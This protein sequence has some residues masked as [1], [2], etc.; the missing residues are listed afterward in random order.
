[1]YDHTLHCRRKRFCRY[2][3]QAFSTEEILT[4]HIKDWFKINGKQRIIMSKKGEYVKFK[5][6]ERKIKSPFISYADF[7]SILVLE[8]NGK[9]NQ[10]ESYTNKYINI[11]LAVMD[12]NLVCTDDKFRKP[13]KTYLGEDAVYN[14]INSL[15]KESKYCSGVLKKHFNKELVMTKEDNENF[16][17][18]AK[19]WI[20]DNGYID[21]DVKVRDH[22]HITGQYRASAHRDCNINLRLN[23]KIPV[24]FRNLKNYDSYLIM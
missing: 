24:V 19:C 9:Q 10:E 22:C 7:E 3:L 23:Q 13:F 15:I 14:F 16:K 8:N 12:I 5:N 6:Y 18:S 4:S 17:N 20:C 1:M 21:N 11:M 2:C